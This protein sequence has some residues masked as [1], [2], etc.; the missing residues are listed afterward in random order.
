MPDR[1][2]LA[3]KLRWRYLKWL[4]GLA[5]ALAMTPQLVRLAATRQTAGISIA[6]FW[7]IL[8]VQIGYAVD[9]YFSRNRML[10]LTISFASLV[11]TGII[12]L[13]YAV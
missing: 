11:T 1:D 6:M 10:L 9:G 13:Y 8:A 4:F 2:V 5:N 3:A 7:V 12:I